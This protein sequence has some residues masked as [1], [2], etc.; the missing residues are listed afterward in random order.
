MD[1]LLAG[2]TVGTF[3]KDLVELV[4]NIKN[5]IDKV[6]ELESQFACHLV[7]SGA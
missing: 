1:P 7:L 4:Q 6:R 5:S 3:V 2:I